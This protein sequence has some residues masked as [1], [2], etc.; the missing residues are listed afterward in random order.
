MVSER[1]HHKDVKSEKIFEIGLT[2]Q[3]ILAF[4]KF[5]FRYFV[6]NNRAKWRNIQ[7]VVFLRYALFAT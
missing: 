6:T 1:G 7:V 4:W 3:K 5:N 2:T